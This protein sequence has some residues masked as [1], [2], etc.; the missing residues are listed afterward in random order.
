MDSKTFTFTDK[1]SSFS[2]NTTRKYFGAGDGGDMKKSSILFSSNPKEELYSGYT[3]LTSK[4]NGYGTD[5]PTVV[6]QEEM[7]Y[8]NVFPAIL[9]FLGLLGLALYLIF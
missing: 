1:P 3:G 2:K 7:S 8:N 5:L 4:A 9:A 6:K